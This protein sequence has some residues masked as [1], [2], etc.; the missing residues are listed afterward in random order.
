MVDRI[1]YPEI[2]SNTLDIEAL[3]VSRVSDID[4]SKIRPRRG[5]IIFYTIYNEALI[6]GFGISAKNNSLTDFGGWIRYPIDHT[7]LNGTFREFQEETYSI[8]SI[9]KDYLKGCMSI[10]SNISFEIFVPATSNPVEMTNKFRNRV[11]SE[12]DNEIK[13]LIW[14]NS[15]QLLLYLNDP[16]SSIHP[17]INHLLIHSYR[18]FGDISEFLWNSLHKSDDT[19]HKSEDTLHKSENTLHKS[20]DSLQKSGNSLQKSE[21]S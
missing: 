15:K 7:A 19:L 6:F 9:T 20:E 11:N 21:D 17:R 14:I 8:F 10:I 16:H 18:T 12:T 1:D 2:L 13:D 4:W 3:D 5:G